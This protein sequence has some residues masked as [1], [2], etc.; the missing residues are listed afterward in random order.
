MA[1]RAARAMTIGTVS[2]LTSRRPGPVR[3][4][5]PI[6]VGEALLDAFELAKSWSLRSCV[7]GAV[8]VGRVTAARSSTRAVPVH[9]RLLPGVR[10]PR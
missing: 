9:A 5:V 2:S 7:L 4:T 6:D 10:I 8:V 1:G 3:V